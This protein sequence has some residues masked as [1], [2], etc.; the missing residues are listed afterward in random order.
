M[1]QFKQ[2]MLRD[3]EKILVVIILM[4]AFIGTYLVEEKFIILNFYGTT[5]N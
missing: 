1:E 2:F 3:F 4:A 5:P